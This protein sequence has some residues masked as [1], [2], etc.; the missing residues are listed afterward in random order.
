MKMLDRFLLLKLMNFLTIIIHQTLYT[1]TVEKV[2]KRIKFQT[3]KNKKSLTR[4][5][6]FCSK[7]F[8]N[9]SHILQGL[10]PHYVVE[11]KSIDLFTT[12]NSQYNHSG[13]W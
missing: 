10:I 1:A 8:I 9:K 13:L 6:K 7:I 12:L 11:F 4:S 5:F 2:R 3:V